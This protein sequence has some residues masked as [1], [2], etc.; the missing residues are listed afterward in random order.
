MRGG[1]YWVRFTV[2]LTTPV[3]P[4]KIR[5]EYAVFDPTYYI[6]ILHLEKDVIEFHGGGPGRCFAQIAPPSPSSKAVIRA[7]SPDIDKQPDESLG[8]LF[9]ERVAVQCR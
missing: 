1:R 2:P 4:S 3:D 6:E 9:A 8:A 5:L 7:R